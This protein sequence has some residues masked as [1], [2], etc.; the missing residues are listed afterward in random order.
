MWLHSARSGIPRGRLVEQTRSAKKTFPTPKQCLLTQFFC[1]SEHL[2]FSNPTVD[3]T[4]SNSPPKWRV[5]PSNLRAAAAARGIGCICLTLWFHLQTLFLFKRRRRRWL[6][7]PSNWHALR[8]A[9]FLYARGSWGFTRGG[10][11][12][13]RAAGAFPSVPIHDNEL[14]I[15]SR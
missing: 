6:V 1:G 11:E 14:E 7:N 13:G 9:Y 5:D 10:R 8:K 3:A 4:A 15:Q 2:S 12:G